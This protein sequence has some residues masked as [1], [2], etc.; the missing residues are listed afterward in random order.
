MDLAALASVEDPTKKPSNL[1]LRNLLRGKSLGV[2]SGQSIAIAM[3]IDPIDD[4]DLRVGKAQV[5]TFGDSPTL[6]SLHGSFSDNAPLWYYVLAEAQ[7]DWFKRATGAGGKGD[8]EPVR[9]G[10][11]GG[12]IVAETIIGLLWADGSSYLRQAPNWQPDG[13]RSMGD[14]LK[15]A[16]DL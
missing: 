4:S 7:V 6:E 8:K 2:A 1:A 3:G 9:L 15:W 11:V 12:R 14:I 5:G 13:F 10:A 16:L